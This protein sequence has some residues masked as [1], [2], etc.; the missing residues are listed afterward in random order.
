[1][2]GRELD[3]YS[4]KQFLDSKSILQIA[5]IRCEIRI[6][7]LVIPQKWQKS[8]SKTTISGDTVA[9]KQKFRQD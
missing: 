1:M 3:P 2:L 4:T 8:D 5:T 7:A 9:R 6:E